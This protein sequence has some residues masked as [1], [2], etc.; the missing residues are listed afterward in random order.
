MIGLSFRVFGVAQPKGS[1]RAISRGMHAPIVTD[2]NRNVKSWA[3]L[4]AAGASQFLDS[5][6][7]RRMILGAVRVRMVFV[8]PRPKALDRAKHLDA[9]HLKAPDIDKLSRAVLDALTSVV[10]RDD[11]Q[12]VEV[13]AC[14]RYT[15]VGELPHVSIEIDELGSMR[16]L[17]LYAEM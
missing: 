1:M 5:H 17:P 9:P 2:S 8:L 6:P 13:G 4:V 12:V 15:R 14:K 3:Q 11:G 16:E 7:A 10:Y